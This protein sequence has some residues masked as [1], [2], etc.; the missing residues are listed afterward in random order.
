MDSF[1][2]QDTILWYKN[3][4]EVCE[5]FKICNNFKQNIDEIHINNQKCI[6]KSIPAYRFSKSQ[7]KISRTKSLKTFAKCL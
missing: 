6:G 5:K 2:T 1:G 3:P 4:S 7:E